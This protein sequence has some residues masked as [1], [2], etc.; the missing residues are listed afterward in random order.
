MRAAVRLT[1]SLVLAAASA[2]TA[3]AQ[4]GAPFF[5]GK[6]VRILISAGVAG[7]YNEYARLLASHM[8]HHLAGKPDFIVQSMPGAG[9]LLATNY[10][11]AQAPQ[12]GTTIGLIHSSVPLAPLF[13]TQGARFDALKFHW[14]GS[15][16][17]SDGPCTA[18]HTAPAK[19]WASL[20]ET[21]FIVG[22][23]GV[24]SQMDIYPAVL[25]KLFGT[26]IKVIGGY[27]D[28]ASIFHAMEREEIHGRCGPQITAIK[29]LRP[30]WLSERKIVIPIMVSERRSEE[31]PDAPS[32]MELAK[33]EPTRQQLRL[34]IVTQD[35]DRPVLAPPGVPPDRVKELREA[36]NATMLDPAFRADIDRL[37]L[38]LDWVRGEDVANTLATAYAM[39]PEVVAAAKETMVG[40]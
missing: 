34:L 12:D 31:F 30:H 8:G 10:L 16:D 4:D 27:K 35:L 40:K 19:T 32:V 26:K 33:D 18:W 9:G 2:G 20:L 36:F 17:R 23:S 13:G 7:G 21:Q 22:S 25:N 14:L 11:Y 24:G 6:T 3:L 15:M 29:S 39:P 1:C 5:K 37:R 28:G 38:T